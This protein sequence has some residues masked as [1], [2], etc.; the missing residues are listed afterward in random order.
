MTRHDNVNHPKHY[1]TGTIETIEFVDQVCAHYPGDEAFSVGS[2]LKYLARAPHKN[3]KLEDLKKAAWYINHTIASVE[4][5]ERA[6]ASAQ[7]VILGI[8]WFELPLSIRRM[9]WKETNYNRK[10][11]SEDFTTR[12]PQL[13]AAV[14]VEIENDKREIAAD[15]A[16]ARE[17][18][19]RAQQPP[20]EQCL[21]PEAPCCVRCLRSMGVAD[22]PE[23]ETIRH[24]PYVDLANAPPW[25]RTI[26]HEH[27]PDPSKVI[28][29][30]LEKKLAM[31]RRLRS[32]KGECK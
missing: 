17:L 3:G 11:P 26:L 12:L 30:E 24:N 13:L 5:K 20:C 15:T 25:L 28:I 19:S 18:L 14:Q 6:A 21:R 22:R 4:D 16:R 23:P 32:G 31:L 7:S 1:N 27:F 9:W 2:A 8:I 10:P 29:E